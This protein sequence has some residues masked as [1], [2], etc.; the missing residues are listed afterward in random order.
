MTATATKPRF[1]VEPAPLAGPTT[2]LAS[3]ALA[4][5]ARAFQEVSAHPEADSPTWSVFNNLMP[6]VVARLQRDGV[7]V[8][9]NTATQVVIAV[10]NHQWTLTSTAV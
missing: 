9:S 8:V 3:I 1:T 4:A 7:N 5:V 2:M 6:A 10:E